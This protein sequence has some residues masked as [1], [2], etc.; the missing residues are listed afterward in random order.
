VVRGEGQVREQIFV[1]LLFLLRFQHGVDLEL[2]TGIV[3]VVQG[4][5]VLD[6]SPVFPARVRGLPAAAR[7]LVGGR[8][9]ATQKISY[10]GPG[11]M[12]SLFMGKPQGG[13]PF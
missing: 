8:Q 3:D 12:G 6:V 4:V 2:V 5:L 7:L 10:R 11:S 13:V 9:S 1:D